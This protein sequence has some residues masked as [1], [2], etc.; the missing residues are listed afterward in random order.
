[1]DRIPARLDVGQG[2]LEGPSGEI[3][4]RCPPQ[5]HFGQLADTHHAR[6][7]G[8]VSMREE[9]KNFQSRTYAS[10]EVARFC[11]LDL[12]PEAPWKCPDN[13]PRY[14]RRFADVGWEHGTLV[15][16]PV[17]A[18]PDVPGAEAAELLQQAVQIVSAAGPEVLAQ[19]E[20]EEAERNRVADRRSRHGGRSHGRGRL[21]G[22]GVDGANRPPLLERFK[23]WWRRLG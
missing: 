21:P 11:A 5:V 22:S 16:G 14:E 2:S 3:G 12:A 17:E 1:M 13:C 23:E 6:H 19:V 9:C 18:E 20:R 7:D 8:A 10:G 15:D 4:S